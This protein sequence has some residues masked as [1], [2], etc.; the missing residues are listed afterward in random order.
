MKRLLI[1]AA[2]VLALSP[3]GSCGNT[4]ESSDVNTDTVA[5]MAPVAAPQV[6]CSNYL[7]CDAPECQEQSVTEHKITGARHEK[8]IQAYYQ[9]IGQPLPAEPYREYSKDEIVALLDATCHDHRLVYDL[10]TLELTQTFTPEDQRPRPAGEKNSYSFALFN[11]ILSKHPTTA[12]FRF[13]RAKREDGFLTM[14]IQALDQA[15]TKLMHA[16]LSDA[17]PGQPGGGGMYDSTKGKK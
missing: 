13:S 6:D 14:V 12:K 5:K 1:L 7:N 15:N 2:Y 3:A 8:M 16:D 11:G 4:T 17:F 9:H 10:N